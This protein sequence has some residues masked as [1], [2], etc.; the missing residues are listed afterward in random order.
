MQRLLHVTFL[1]PNK[2]APQSKSSRIGWPVAVETPRK[3][4]AGLVLRSFAQVPCAPLSRSFTLLYCLSWTERAPFHAARSRPTWFICRLYNCCRR[5][6]C[7]DTRSIQ[8]LPKLG[9][10]N[11][12]V[13][14]TLS[15]IIFIFQ[16]SYAFLIRFL[17]I[18][19]KRQNVKRWI[20]IW[21]T[22]CEN[23]IIEESFE[24]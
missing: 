24:G 15:K 11:K 4:K 19:C 7:A 2:N 14:F 8:S 18:I 6:F 21:K 23:F 12:T 22:K 10:Q 17:R 3:Q 13:N 9:G 20:L 5:S 16:M 1:K